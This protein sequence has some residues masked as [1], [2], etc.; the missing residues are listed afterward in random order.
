M[1]AGSVASA[2]NRPLRE[3]EN[4]RL[5]RTPTQMPRSA[6]AAVPDPGAPAI[7]NRPPE[8]SSS[9]H[10][11]VLLPV[12][13]LKPPPRAAATAPGYRRAIGIAGPFAQAAVT[14]LVSVSD[15]ALDRMV[16][17]NVL[18]IPLQICGTAG[19]GR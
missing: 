11:Q 1:T 10:R 16:A 2:V 17:I 8:Q 6:P 9:L 19:I 3:L 12:R 4:R 14:N 18:R 5:R 13:I 15:G 7:P